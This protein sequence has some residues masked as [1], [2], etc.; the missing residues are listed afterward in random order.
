MKTKPGL[1]LGL[2]IVAGILVLVSF[3]NLCEE[4]ADKVWGMFSSGILLLLSLGFTAFYFLERRK[5]RTLTVITL[6]LD[7]QKFKA[8][9]ASG[10]SL[11]KFLKSVKDEGENPLIVLWNLAKIGEDS[12]EKNFSQKI[13]RIAAEWDTKSER[14][15]N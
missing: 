7:G 14:T 15:L 4:G 11:H 10:N 6:E 2:A 9:I 12:F 13:Y 8:I 5:E 1:F 3:F